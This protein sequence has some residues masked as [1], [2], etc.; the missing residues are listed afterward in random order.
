MISGRKR[1]NRN[2]YYVAWICP[3][4]E[5]ELLPACLM[6][7]EEHDAPEYNTHYDENTYIFGSIKGH[8]VVIATLPEGLTGNVYAARLSG[9]MFKSF[10]FIRMALLVG[11]GGGIPR[12]EISD[13]SLKNLHLGDVVVGWPGDGKP[14]CVYYNRGREKAEGEF[15][16]VSTFRNP[17]WRLT[18]ALAVLPTR[19]LMGET[20]FGEQLSRL[21]AFKGEQGFAAPSCEHDRLF[22]LVSRHKGDYGSECTACDQDELI[23][24]PP[25]FEEDRSKIVFHFGRIAT[26]DT[27]ISDGKRR[28]QIRRRCDEALCVEMEAAGVEV[29]RQ[30]LVIR[31]IS[32]YADA[33]K[34]DMWRSYA[35]GNAAAFA[36]ELLCMIPSGAV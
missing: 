18:N 36:R 27:V 30:C 28:E 14:A 16:L 32:N 17:D 4:A 9:P 35:A 33:H 11:T 34:N 15:E 8:T 21:S 7:D 1:L 5:V 20:T 2:D 31:G 6:L 13:N 12:P 3:V 24:R 29:N 25:R 19:H 22:R 10:P 23:A 26:G